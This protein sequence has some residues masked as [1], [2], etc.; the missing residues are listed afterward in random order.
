MKIF[1]NGHLYSGG[2]GNKIQ[3]WKVRDIYLLFQIFY[4]GTAQKYNLEP[5]VL[6]QIYNYKK[7]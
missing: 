6:E 7:L 5:G 2:E 4:K 3:K 1:W